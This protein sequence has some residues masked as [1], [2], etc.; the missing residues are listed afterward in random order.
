[1]TEKGYEMERQRNLAKEVNKVNQDYENTLNK[2]NSA[3]N[4]FNKIKVDD[5]AT[6]EEFEASRKK[7]LQTVE[8]FREVLK[9]KI[10][11]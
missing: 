8:A 7:A 11:I 2:A 4:T 1:M 5:S 6:R 10:A 9:A 3:L